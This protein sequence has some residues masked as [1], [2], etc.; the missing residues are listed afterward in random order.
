MSSFGGYLPV[1]YKS[2]YL[3][4]KSYIYYFTRA[5]QQEFTNTNVKV[6]VALPGAVKTNKKVLERIN[7]SGYLG[8]VTALTADEFV[9]NAIRKTLNGKK[10]I[11]EGRLNRIF[12]SVATITPQGILLNLLR[13]TFK[14]RAETR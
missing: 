11:I 1:P 8:K 14:N 6:C 4:S 10:V 2:V 13:K 3:A 9:K 5:L 12:F 7:D